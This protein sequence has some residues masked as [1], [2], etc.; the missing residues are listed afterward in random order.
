MQ[1]FTNLYVVLQLLSLKN[2]AQFLP[3][4]IEGIDDNKNVNANQTP[5]KPPT[6]K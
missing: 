4:D 5:G 6:S 1:L 2:K 3:S